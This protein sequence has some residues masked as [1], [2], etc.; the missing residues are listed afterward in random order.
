MEIQKIN[1]KVA[2]QQ[3]TESLKYQQAVVFVNK[4]TTIMV[5]FKN[6]RLVTIYGFFILEN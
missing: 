5:I 2:I 4:H 6:A 1:V 3:I